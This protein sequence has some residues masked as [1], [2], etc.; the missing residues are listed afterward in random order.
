MKAYDEYG[1]YE[2]PLFNTDAAAGG[3]GGGSGDNDRKCLCRKRECDSPSPAGMFTIKL[4]SVVT[5]V[6]S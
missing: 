3:Q 2:S 5:N 4:R 6:P 1:G